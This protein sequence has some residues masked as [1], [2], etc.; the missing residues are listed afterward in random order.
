MIEISPDYIKNKIWECIKS[1][2]DFAKEV[3]LIL[4]EQ[5][6]SMFRSLGFREE[7]I[8]GEQVCQMLQCSA[9]TL[10]LYRKQGMP[11]IKSSPN[12]YLASEVLEWYKHNKQLR[13]KICL[14]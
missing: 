10:A 6:P 3:T 11:Y 7:Y 14:R 4:K 13:R 9:S 1:D 5:L 12:K 2:E 8:T